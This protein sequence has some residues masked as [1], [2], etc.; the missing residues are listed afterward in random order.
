VF[1]I[2]GHG[3][4]G[5]HFGKIQNQGKLLFPFGAEDLLHDPFPFKGMLI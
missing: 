4:E 2:L 3:K 1:E 5:F